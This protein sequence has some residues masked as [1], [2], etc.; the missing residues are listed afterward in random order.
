MVHSAKTKIERKGGQHEA[1]WVR[2]RVLRRPEI[3]NSKAPTKTELH[4][5]HV[6]GLSQWG[7]AGLR[8]VRSKV[9]FLA[10]TKKMSCSTAN[11]FLLP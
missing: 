6:H 3:Q 2:S 1:A 5:A 9:S 11:V 8:K 4:P 7:Q 10:L